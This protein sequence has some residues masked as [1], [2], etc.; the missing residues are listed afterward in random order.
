M[1][2]ALRQSFGGLRAKALPGV[3]P[4]GLVSPFV[5]N[6]QKSF[7]CPNGIQTDPASADFGKPFQVSYGYNF[8]VG[9][10]GGITLVEI[11]I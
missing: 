5:E 8:V 11:T 1:V 3:P 6:S 2:G 9:G 10:P 7:W 4:Q